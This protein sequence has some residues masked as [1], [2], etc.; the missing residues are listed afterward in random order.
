MLFSEGGGLP[1]SPRADGQTK[2]SEPSVVYVRSHS[3]LLGFSPSPIG[4]LQLPSPDGGQTIALS[5]AHNTNCHEAIVR[6]PTGAF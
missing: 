2:A 6:V 5:G 1:P 3:L 4:S